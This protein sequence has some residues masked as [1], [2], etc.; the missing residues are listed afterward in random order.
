MDRL[1]VTAVSEITAATIPE[2]Y[3][4]KRKTIHRCWRIT[5]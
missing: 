2:D 5:V 3:R 1:A 4:S